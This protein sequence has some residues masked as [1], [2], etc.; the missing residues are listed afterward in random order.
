MDQKPMREFGNVLVCKQNWMAVGAELQFDAMTV[1]A[2]SFKFIPNLPDTYNILYPSTM[3]WTVSLRN[4]IK[5]NSNDWIEIDFVYEITQLPTN[6]MAFNFAAPTVHSTVWHAPFASISYSFC[7]KFEYAADRKIWLLPQIIRC[8]NKCYH[9]F[10]FML[11][12]LWGNCSAKVKLISHAKNVMCIGITLLK[13]THTL[14]FRA[15]EQHI[16]LQAFIY[17]NCECFFLFSSLLLNKIWKRGKSDI[18][19][20]RLRPP[21]CGCVANITG[22]VRNQTA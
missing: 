18:H 10:H 5:A 19:I 3:K 17:V 1:E 6:S 12:I 7:L 15:V 11:N 2:I 13:C 21:P 14:E 20:F 16:D 4:K 9:S 22:C 8:L